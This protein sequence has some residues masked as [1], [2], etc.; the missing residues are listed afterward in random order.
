MEVDWRID[1]WSKGSM[2][3]VSGGSA[4][5]NHLTLIIR[6]WRGVAWVAFELHSHMTNGNIL[7]A[8]IV[9][10]FFF[11]HRQNPRALWTLLPAHLQ[12]Y[13]E[14]ILAPEQCGAREEK[15]ERQFRTTHHPHNT[16]LGPD[17]KKKLSRFARM[18]L[19]PSRVSTKNKQEAVRQRSNRLEI[20]QVSDTWLV[21]TA[22]QNS[23]P[24]HETQSIDH[25][26][27]R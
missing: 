11:G 8:M 18:N 21:N 20:S 24:M 26:S 27:P 19:A 2:G 25:L 4:A 23:R 1:W 17:K 14:L 12:H 3:S 15:R 16:Q 5:S 22:S 13:K 7:H 10:F 6:A 9:I